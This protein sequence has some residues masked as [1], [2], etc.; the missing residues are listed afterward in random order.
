MCPLRG[1]ITAEDLIKVLSQHH[2]YGLCDR[3][4]YSIIATDDLV[5]RHAAHTLAGAL[6]PLRDGGTVDE[7]N[8]AVKTAFGTSSGQLRPSGVMEALRSTGAGIPRFQLTQETYGKF[9]TK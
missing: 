7:L 9:K 2:V 8:E 5:D 1:R 3:V 4:W 6:D